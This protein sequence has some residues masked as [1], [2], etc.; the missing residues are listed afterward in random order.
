MNISISSGDAAALAYHYHGAA[1]IA[2]AYREVCRAV[3]EV[4]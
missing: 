3:A 1:M 4:N 2:A